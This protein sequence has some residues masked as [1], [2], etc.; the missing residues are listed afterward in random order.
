EVGGA[1][2]KQTRQ[3]RLGGHEPT[4]RIASAGDAAS[5]QRL[6]GTVRALSPAER[7]ES[8]LNS[9]LLVS[10][11]SGPA[12]R[13][14]IQAGDVILALNGTP[15]RDPDQLQRL[16]ARSEEHTSELQ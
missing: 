3:A 14:G 1:G 11:A 9:G 13:A 16:L 2:A 7:A 15:V 12:A 10:D 8:G 6:G 4:V 5:P